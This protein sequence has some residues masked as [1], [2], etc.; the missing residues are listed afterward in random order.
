MN[1]E[2]LTYGEYLASDV[3]KCTDSPTG[4]HHW[5]EIQHENGEF[6]TGLWYCKWC[7]DIRSFPNHYDVGKMFI[8]VGEED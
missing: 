3:W 2:I 6:H 8:M 7:E 1:G 5:I 4:A